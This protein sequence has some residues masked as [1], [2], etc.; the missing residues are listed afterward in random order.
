MKIPRKRHRSA[1]AGGQAEVSGNTDA[2]LLAWGPG[3]PAAP[4]GAG[5]GCQAIKMDP[6]PLYAELWWLD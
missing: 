6:N 2:H 3:G 5:A 4:C 1:A